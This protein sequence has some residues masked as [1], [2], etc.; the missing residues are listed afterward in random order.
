MYTENREGEKKMEK[1]EK[2]IQK[3]GFE[4]KKVIKYAKKLE[5]RGK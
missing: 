1:L 5:K 2:L 4:H 3:Y